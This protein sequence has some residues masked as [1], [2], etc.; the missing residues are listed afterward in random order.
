MIAKLLMFSDSNVITRDDVMYHL[1]DERIA[2]EPDLPSCTLKELER[3]A[4]EKALR[5]YGTTLS[6]KKEAALALGISLSSLYA[7]IKRFG[8]E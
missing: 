5:T 4:I 1:R 7:R 3:R 2:D 8:L 6:G